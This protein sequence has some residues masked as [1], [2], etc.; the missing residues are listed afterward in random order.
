[1]DA[2][3]TTLRDTASQTGGTVDAVVIGGTT[4]AAA[5]VTTINAN[6]NATLGD[7]VGDAHTVTGQLVITDDAASGLVILRSGS[8]DGVQIG[9]GT[10][11]DGAKVVAVNAGQSDFTPFKIT[12]SNIQFSIRTGVGT[13]TEK[14]RFDTGGILLVGKTTSD[15]GVVGSELAPSGLG[16]FTV[17]GGLCM[18][19]TRL[20]NDGT[21]ISFFQDAAEEGTISVSGT[22]IALNGAHLGRW[23]QIDGLVPP[24]GTVLSSTGEMCQWLVVEWIDEKGSKQCEIYSPTKHGQRKIGDSWTSTVQVK[25]KTE[26]VYQT[27]DITEN[28]IIIVNGVPTLNIVQVKRA[29]H[30]KIAVQY[31]GKP[32]VNSDGQGLFADVPV[33]LEPMHEWEE[34]VTLTYTL[35][36]EDNEQLIKVKISDTPSDRTVYS[37]MDRIDDDGDPTTAGVGDFVIRVTGPVK[38][39]DLLESAG[40]GTA[41]AQAN[42]DVRGPWTIG[43]AVRNDPRTDDRIIPW[44]ALIG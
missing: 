4:R 22:T 29:I 6:G 39:G 15:S 37:I 36:E 42:Q 26:V 41:R 25:R 9:G 7:V 18:Y 13:E 35:V 11:A 23:A 1:M 33:E 12:A 24:R 28:R 5:S 19:V 3:F 43:K 16:A 44:L 14:A 10:A 32:F 27:E 8:G 38:N 31:G 20:V 34:L 40:D 17:S 2:N 21:L 30:R